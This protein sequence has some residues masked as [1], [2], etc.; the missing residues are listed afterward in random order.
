MR[1]IG[2]ALMLALGLVACSSGHPSTRGPTTT[3][4][5]TGSKGRIVTTTSQPTSTSIAFSAADT[6]QRD[7]PLKAEPFPDTTG[8]VDAKNVQHHSGG[9]YLSPRRAADIVLR[10]LEC[11][12]GGPQRGDANTGCLQADVRFFAHYVDW[13]R[14][15]GGQTAFVGSWGPDREMYA[16]TIFGK[17]QLVTTAASL[18]LPAY[19]SWQTFQIDATT[20]R[21]MM[22]GGLPL[23]EH[24]PGVH[25]FRTRALTSG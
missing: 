14:V 5:T 24:F 6:S 19:V 10:R 15:E 3:A 7:R 9:P 4:L 8:V 2:C 12:L 16:V 1:Q 21:I 11:T 13:W 22:T 20:G 25:T 18:G 23:P 17:L